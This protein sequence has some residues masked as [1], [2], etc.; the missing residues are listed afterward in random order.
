MAKKMQDALDKDVPAQDTQARAEMVKRGLKVTA[1]D[2]AAVRGF[3]EM[4]DKFAASMK[5]GV[6][7]ADMYDLA[8]RERDAFRKTRGSK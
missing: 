3:R 7:A 2:P 8:T 6:V 1:P 5:G 4:A